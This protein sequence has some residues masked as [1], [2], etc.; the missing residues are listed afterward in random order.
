MLIFVNLSS[1]VWFGSSKYKSRL[2][3]ITVRP[4]ATD[5]TSKESNT[6]TIKHCH[7]I[8]CRSFKYKVCVI[9]NIP[10][11]FFLLVSCSFFNLL[12]FFL[13]PRKKNKLKLHNIC[14]R[15]V[16]L[17]ILYFLS[18]KSLILF[19]LPSFDPLF[20]TSA[21]FNDNLFLLYFFLPVFSPS[22]PSF[23]F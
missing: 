21:F 10:L 22:L 23:F 14:P 6:Q 20:L 15:S 17:D 2:C 8:K 18:F 13:R 16:L 4:N 1:L 11:S 3:C 19:Y 5:R 12:L 7:V 9:M